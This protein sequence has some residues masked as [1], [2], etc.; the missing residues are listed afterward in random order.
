MRVITIQ[1]DICDYTQ[2]TENACPSTNAMQNKNTLFLELLNTRLTR[3][4]L[5]LSLLVRRQIALRLGD[6]AP[7]RHQNQAE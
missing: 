7:H 6:F 1:E 3:H 5:Q 4:S 2:A